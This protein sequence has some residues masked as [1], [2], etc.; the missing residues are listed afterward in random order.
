[1][2]AEGC[3]FSLPPS[4]SRVSQERRGLQA[5]PKWS[6][7]ATPGAFLRNSLDAVVY[8]VYSAHTANG[9]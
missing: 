4:P 1:M 6:S 2:H 9:G 3:L 7:R 5:S 8:R